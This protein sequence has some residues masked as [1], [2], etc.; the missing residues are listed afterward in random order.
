M[1]TRITQNAVNRMYNRNYSN[2]LTSMTDLMNKISA[3][4]KFTRASENPISA[5]RALAV[6]KSMADVSTY[7]S[8]L[9]SAKQL[10]RTAESVLRE[11]IN[12]VCKKVITKVEMAC[13]DPSANKE[14]REILAHELRGIADDLIK[15]M[16]SDYADRRL[17]GGTNNSEDILPFSTEKDADGRTIVLYNGE[18][19]NNISNPDDFP[20]SKPIFSD[21]G[22]GIKYD[23]AGNVDPDTAMDVSLNGAELT[24]CGEEKWKSAGGTEYTLSNNFIQLVYDAADAAESGN[25]DKLNAMLDAFGSAQSTI[26]MG[27]TS[28][29]VKQETVDYNITRFEEYNYNLSEAQLNLEGMSEEDLAK[30]ITEWK[31]LDAA[32]N[33][34]LS[35]SSK[36]IPNSVWD[37][38]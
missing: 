1:I 32:Y 5:A 20:F 37:F 23:A 22:I 38:M 31:S 35:M 24:G 4:R 36:V 11:D 33:A 29:G 18:N 6:R 26:L 7:Q 34:V 19:V 30:A 25:T 9:S 14:E 2:N 15:S 28:L 27:I 3:Q 12:D 21:I 17:F 10:F 8:N 13:N 16:N